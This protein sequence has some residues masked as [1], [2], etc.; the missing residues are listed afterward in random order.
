MRA[1]RRVLIV[2]AISLFAITRGD[3][4]GDQETLPPAFGFDRDADQDRAGG[5][6]PSARQTK[7]A[8]RSGHVFATCAPAS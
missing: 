3:L 5:S 7:V 6:P 2:A 1:A 8:V 4:T